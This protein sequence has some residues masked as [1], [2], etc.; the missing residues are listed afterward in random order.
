[1]D[2]E[3]SFVWTVGNAV[4]PAGTVV[5][6]TNIAHDTLPITLTAVNPALAGT[7]NDFGFIRKNNTRGRR[8]VSIVTT[9]Q[10]L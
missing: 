8:V 2:I 9:A 10:W 1:V 3:P 7:S 4:I 6:M 5:L